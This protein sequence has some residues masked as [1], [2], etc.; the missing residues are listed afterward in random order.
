VCSEIWVPSGFF[1]PFTSPINL[2]IV[3]DVHYFVVWV[4][5]GTVCEV[6]VRMCVLESLL[7]VLSLL[8]SSVVTVCGV[9]FVFLVLHVM[10]K[11]LLMC[12]CI[13]F[14]VP[15]RCVDVNG[16]YKDIRNQIS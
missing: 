2:F 7:E 16:K 15:S 10:W 4:F 13:A 12:A 14:R 11:W 5:L 9:V 6:E 1:F 8:R 3:N